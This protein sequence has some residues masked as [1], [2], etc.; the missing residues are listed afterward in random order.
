MRK[1]LC[2]ITR[3]LDVLIIVLIL[4]LIVTVSIVV[5][6]VMIVVVVVCILKVLYTFDIGDSIMGNTFGFGPKFGFYII[7]CVIFED[8]EL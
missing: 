1:E 5:V 3:S 2:L 7:F 4:I 8:E 6:L